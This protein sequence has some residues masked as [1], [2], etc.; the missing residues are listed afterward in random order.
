MYVLLMPQDID[1]Q[2]YPLEHKS[3]PTYNDSKTQNTHRVV[4]YHY[5]SLKHAR[6]SLPLHD[7]HLDNLTANLSFASHSVLGDSLTYPLPLQS[8]HTFTHWHTLRLL[9]GDAR[10]CGE[11]SLL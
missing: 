2:H 6:F 10:R 3:Q 9:W 5:P 1:T 7:Q 11:Q 8:N 4:S